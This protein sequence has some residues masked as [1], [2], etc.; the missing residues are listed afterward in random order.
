MRLNAIVKAILLLLLPFIHHNCF[1]KDKI[2][3][4]S[5]WSIKH[6]ELLS[7]HDSVFID[8]LWNVNRDFFSKQ[9]YKIQG[10]HKDYLKLIDKAHSLNKNTKNDSIAFIIDFLNFDY[11]FYTSQDVS[12]KIS[13]GKALWFNRKYANKEAFVRLSSRLNGLYRGVG[14]HRE[15]LDVIIA[16]KE[17]KELHNEENLDI[18]ADLGAVYYDLKQYK[19]ALFHFRKQANIYKSVGRYIGYSSLLNN[20][21][22][23]HNIM[24][25]RDSALIYINKSMRALLKTKFENELFSESY[26]AHFRN[27]LE[28]N[29]LSYTDGGDNDSLLNLSFKTLRSSLREV[30]QLWIHGSYFKIAETFLYMGNLKSARIYADSCFSYAKVLGNHKILANNYE[31]QGKLNMALS[32]WNESQKYFAKAKYLKDSLENA[33]N[34]I[35]AEGAIAL[36]E[37]NEKKL[38]IEKLENEVKHAKLTG[39]LN[40]T[41]NKMYGWIGLALLEVILVLAYLMFRFKKDRDRLKKESLK[42]KKALKRKTWPA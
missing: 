34:K 22:L 16:D 10:Y 14:L 9:A 11:V 38:K 39:E 33:K 25:K 41:K 5:L 29:K 17:Y 15:R 7:Y 23:V 26:V 27:I 4:D 20:I 8:S 31:L 32:N 1:A 19:K 12:E 28:W 35:K 6:A 30:D 18:H 2:S 3:I 24:A 36:F 13:L 37:S 42:M 21:S 40:L